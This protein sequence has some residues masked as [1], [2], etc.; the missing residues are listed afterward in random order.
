M[1]RL[2]FAGRTRQ[3]VGFDVSRLISVWCVNNSR[4][5]NLPEKTKIRISY[6]SIR[7]LYTK[8]QD[9][10]T[11]GLKV[12][13]GIKSVTHTRTDKPKAICPTN[14][15]KVGSITRRPL[16]NKLIRQLRHQRN[17][18]Q[19]SSRLVCPIGIKG[20]NANFPRV[21]LMSNM[22]KRDKCQFRR[23]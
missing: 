22:H 14:F 9:T 7:Y 19:L 12:T 11:H 1:P 6:F 23:V 13:G 4:T 3:F 10:N 15:F 18:C 8:F 17:N 16:H 20:K 21:F 5:K 2:I